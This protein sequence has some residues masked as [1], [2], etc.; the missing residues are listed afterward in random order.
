MLNNEIVA[1]GKE[2]VD[3]MKIH[4]DKLNMQTFQGKFIS[5]LFLHTNI[6]LTMVRPLS[7]NEDRAIP[8]LE[9]CPN[10]VVEVS[11]FFSA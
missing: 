2:E 3:K 8:D 1:V 6:D 4:V 7:L 10:E 5:T 11:P 9:V